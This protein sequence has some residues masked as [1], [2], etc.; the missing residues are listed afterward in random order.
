MGSASTE[1]RQA[2]RD[3]REIVLCIAQGDLGDVLDAVAE[4]VAT[5]LAV[6]VIVN[7]R[8]RSNVDQL[9]LLVRRGY[10]VF[11]GALRGQ[12]R[13]FVNR[14]QGYFLPEYA[15]VANAYDVATTDM[16]QRVGTFLLLSGEVGAVHQEQ[17]MFKLRGS[18]LF[19]ISVGQTDMPSVGSDIEVLGNCGWASGRIVVMAAERIRVLREAGA[20]A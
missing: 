6:Q 20:T 2:L 19:F 15:A 16:W 5:P 13:V 14:K 18:D 8:L 10:R 1:I 4:E 11:E 17:Q 12:D 7:A 3:A 9:E